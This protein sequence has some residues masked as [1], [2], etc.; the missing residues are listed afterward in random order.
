[1]DDGFSMNALCLD[2]HRVKNFLQAIGEL[3]EPDAFL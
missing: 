3:S 1:M 2:M